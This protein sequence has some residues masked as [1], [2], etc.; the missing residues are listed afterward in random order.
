MSA[1]GTTDTRGTFPATID[2]MISVDSSHYKIEFSTG[3]VQSD[4]VSAV[5]EPST[6]AM[7]LIGFCGIGYMT[8]RQKKRYALRGSQMKDFL[9][10]TER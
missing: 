3:I 10:T 5:P 4:G 6:W 9:L 1:V 7:M 8:Y 2:P